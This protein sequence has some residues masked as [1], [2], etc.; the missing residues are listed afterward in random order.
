MRAVVLVG[1]AGTRLQ[2]LTAGLPKALVPVVGRPLIEHVLAGLGQHGIT[3]ISF[4]LT[5]PNSSIEDH[6][7]AGRELGLRL[8][9][10]YE[11]EAAGS[12]GAIRN[13]AGRWSEPFLVLNGDI[14]SD[15]DF[16]AFM[17]FHAEGQPAVSMVLCE[18]D[19]PSRYGVA[20]LD[21]AGS[22]TE[23]VEKPARGAAPSHQINAGVWLFDQ[24]VLAQIPAAGFSRVEDEL[25]PRLIA[26]GGGGLRGFQQQG[27]WIDIGTLASYHQANMDLL[28]APLS[29]APRGEHDSARSGPVVIDPSAIVEPGADLRGPL[30]IGPDCRIGAD[31]VVRE[32]VLWDGVRIGADAV[33]ERAVVAS[34]AS[35]RDGARLVGGVV[36]AGGDLAAGEAIRFEF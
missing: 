30:M 2:P 3:Q 36:P 1:G 21:P 11:E 20:L 10:V 34:G 33:V 14:V 7:G 23:F 29:L 28:R 26:P 32:S 6:L 35:I 15:I 16:G 31:A 18:V 22:I 27:Y 4:A 13:V 17:R 19:D 9:Y 24:A 5:R 25:F 8:D 12:G